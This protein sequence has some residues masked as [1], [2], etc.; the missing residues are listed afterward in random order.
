M[1]ERRVQYQYT[2]FYNKAARYPELPVVRRFGAQVTKV[3][4][5][6]IEDLLQ[7]EKDVGDALARVRTPNTGVTFLDCPRS[8]VKRENPEVYDGE[9]QEFEKCLRDYG[10]DLLQAHELFN[11]PNQDPYFTKHFAEYRELFENDVFGPTGEKASV[12]KDHSPPDDICALKAVPKEDY[13]TTLVKDNIDWIERNILS[14]LRR[15]WT[16]QKHKQQHRETFV[17][18]ST[19]KSIMD[20]ST[21]VFSPILF[22]ATIFTLIWIKPLNSRVLIIFIFGEIFALVMKLR[23]VSRGEIFAAT[24]GY[25]AVASMFVSTT[26][27]SS[28]NQ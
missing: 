19:V 13:V 10:R 23:G 24:A 26:S 5:D 16:F 14:H 2:P 9:W 28:V 20:W 17:H 22:T 18:L 6:D 7:K 15:P 11:L 21:C 3:L 1:S 4:Y 27:S 12:Y 8:V 25:F